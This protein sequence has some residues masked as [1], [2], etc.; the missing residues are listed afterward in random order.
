MEEPLAELGPALLARLVRRPRRPAF[1]FGPYVLRAA[2]DAILAVTR[3]PA[4]AL[5]ALAGYG[6]RTS[7]W[8]VTFD[9]LLQAHV[10]APMRGRTLAGFDLTWQLRRLVSL[11]VGGVVDDTIGVPAVYGLGALLLAAAGTVGWTGLR[12]TSAAAA[13]GDDAR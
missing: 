12:D 1:V 7:T 5:G 8:A 6:I 13:T 11:G 3:T 9:S 10:P 2:V 4:V